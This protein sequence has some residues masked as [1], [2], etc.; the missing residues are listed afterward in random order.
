M[1][2]CSYSR[3]WKRSIIRTANGRKLPLERYEPGKGLKLLLAKLKLV[4]PEPYPP[5][6]TLKAPSSAQRYNSTLD[7]SRA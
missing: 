2:W 6:I 4:L 3:L 5:R 1:A 7:I